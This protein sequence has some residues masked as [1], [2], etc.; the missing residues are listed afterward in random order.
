MQRLICFSI[1]AESPAELRFHFLL[2]SGQLSKAL[3]FQRSRGR[4]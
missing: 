2:I 3:E 1:S 4:E